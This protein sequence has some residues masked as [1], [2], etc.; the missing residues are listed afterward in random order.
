KAEEACDRD[1]E[2]GTPVEGH[3]AVRDRPAPRSSPR[4]TERT[5]ARRRRDCEHELRGRPPEGPARDVETEAKRP[6]IAEVGREGDRAPVD[7]SSRGG[8]PGDGAGRETQ[9]AL[10]VE[11]RLG[12][13]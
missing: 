4:G 8:E 7:A 2:Q 3:A 5:Q 12:A 9:H 11:R 1:A 6:P 10:D 13:D